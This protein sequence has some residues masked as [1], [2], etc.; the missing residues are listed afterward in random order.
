MM[1]CTIPSRTLPS[2][3]ASMRFVNR[4][5]QFYEKRLDLKVLEDTGASYCVIKRTEM[6]RST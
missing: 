3:G 6:T 4:S 1:V 5:T 2:E